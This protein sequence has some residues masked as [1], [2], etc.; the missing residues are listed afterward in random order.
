MLLMFQLVTVPVR[1]PN[2]QEFVR[3]NSDASYR[4]ETLVLEFKEERETYLVAPELWPEI[5][6]ELVPKTLLTTI[7]RQNVLTLWPIRLPGP[8]GRQDAWSQ[9]AQEASSMAIG[10]WVRVAANMSLGAYEVFEASGDIPD[11]EWPDVTFEAILNIAFRDRYVQDLN[12]PALRRLR[13]A[14]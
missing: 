9:S 11:P 7:N 4:L 5:S 14:M 13:G 2:R 6:T 12:H 10:R 1:K 8:D 3:V